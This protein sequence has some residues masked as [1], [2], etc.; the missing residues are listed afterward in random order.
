MRQRFAVWLLI[1]I[2]VLSGCAAV[3]VGGIAAGALAVHDRRTMPDL[4]EDQQIEIESVRR[5]END[6]GMDGNTHIRVVSYNGVVLIAGE[7]PSADHRQRAESTVEKV[8]GVRRVVNDLRIGRPSGIGQRLEDMWVTTRAKSTLFGVDVEGFDPTRVKIVTVGG[9][10]Y[11]MG[12]VTQAEADAVL[13]RV[14][15]IRGVDRVVQV[16]ELLSS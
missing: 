12:L 16:F 1:L 5:L 10:L 3:A 8:D 15:Y 13:A 9:N 2:P 6:A 14:R 4:I 11:V 7:V